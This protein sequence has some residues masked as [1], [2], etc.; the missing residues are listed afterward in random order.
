ETLNQYLFANRDRIS[1]LI[2]DDAQNLNKRGQLE[3]LRLVQNLETPQHKPL[4]LVLFGQ[5]EWKRVLAAAPNFAQRINLTY[6]LQALSLDE[7]AK[8]ITFRVERAGGQR[9]QKPIFSDNAIEMIHAYSEGNPRLIVTICRNALL[10]AGRLKK[11]EVDS[12]LILHT[13]EKTTLHD[14]KKH[15]RAKTTNVRPAFTLKD[16][17]SPISKV[18]ATQFPRRDVPATTASRSRDRRANEMLLRAAR[19]KVRSRG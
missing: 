2:I 12:D 19:T 10:L 3:L 16:A 5:L 14:P 8:L 11:E 1:T 15:A 4:N 9:G 17:K 7:L 13:V 6:T 18:R